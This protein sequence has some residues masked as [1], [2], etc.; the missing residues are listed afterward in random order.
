[1]VDRYVAVIGDIVGSRAFRGEERERLQQHLEAL[2]ERLN[3]TFWAVRAAP[4]ELT[5]GDAVKGLLNEIDRLDDL[6]WTMGVEFAGAAVR[7]GIGYGGLETERRDSLSRMDGTA[8]HMARAAV[9]H[10]RDEDRMGGVFRGF[11]AFDPIL[12]GIAG[13]LHAHRARLSPRQMQVTEKLRAAER[14]KSIA[15]SL[16][17][18]PQAV[19][20]YASIAQ[21]PYYRDGEHALRAA[22]RAAYEAAS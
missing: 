5:E 15:E 7:L 12:D 1:M 2:V 17:V 8:F 19:S 21:W 22:L 14:Q 9:E 3:T 16:G 20:R 6:L 11:G 4:F 18:S 13:L 10:A